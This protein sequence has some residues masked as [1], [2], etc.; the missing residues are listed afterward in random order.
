MDARFF[1][2]IMHRFNHEWAATALGMG[3]NQNNGPDLI[4]GNKS[5]ELKF[6][7]VGE[8]SG[9]ERYTRG[10]TVLEYQMDYGENGLLFFWGLGTYELSRPI[11]II[12]TREAGRL[13]R[14]VLK[15]NLWIVNSDWMQQ[16]PPHR[17]KGQTKKSS[18]DNTLRY[19][20]LKSLPRTTVAY[21]VNGGFVHLTDGIDAR[22]F[23]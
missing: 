12:K 11:S 22:L 10:W 1:N 23:D 20:K 18:W 3:V 4:N 19:P 13:E 6:C 15:R 7:L 17:T 9:A 21:R 14:Y 8:K 2:S 16:F 5:I